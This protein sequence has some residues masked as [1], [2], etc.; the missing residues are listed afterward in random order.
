MFVLG[1][2]FGH[3]RH[4]KKYNEGL[5]EATRKSG[6]GFGADYSEFSRAQEDDL[7]LAEVREREDLPGGAQRGMFPYLGQDHAHGADKHF[8]PAKFDPQQTLQARYEFQEKEFAAAQ[9]A[10][11]PPQ[12]VGEELQKKREVP[13]GYVAKNAEGEGKG[14]GVWVGEVVSGGGSLGVWLLWDEAEKQRTDF[15]LLTNPNRRPYHLPRKV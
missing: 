15:L 8:E 4:A 9:M 12:V 6:E 5:G 3:W 7:R 13:P 2:V 10:V 14:G 11:V 1:D